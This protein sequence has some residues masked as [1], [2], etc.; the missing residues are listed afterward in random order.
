MT[1]TP[2]LSIINYEYGGAGA[3]YGA[4]D[5]PTCLE[6]DSFTT[7]N[8][9]TYTYDEGDTLQA[10]LAKDLK[11]EIEILDP[12]SPHITE[13]N[14]Q[15]DAH[16][17]TRV[18]KK[19]KKV[20]VK[21]EPDGSKTYR[22]VKVED[23]RLK[24][25]YVTVSPNGE[26]VTNITETGTKPYDNI[27]S[28]PENWDTE[29]KV[30]YLPDGIKNHRFVIE[31]TERL[32]ATVCKSILAKQFDPHTK[33]LPPLVIGGDH[34]QGLG[35][36]AGSRLAAIVIKL[37]EDDKLELRIPAGKT[38]EEIIDPIRTLAR[39]LWEL[40]KDQTSNIVKKAR[41]L[42]ASIE[43]L[44][45]Q[46]LFEIS[47]NEALYNITL[48]EIPR[49][50]DKTGKYTESNADYSKR[51]TA[52][53]RQKRG[54][55]DATQPDR[56]I[57]PLKELRKFLSTI[58]QFWFDAH[59]DW[60][61]EHTS[62]SKNAH[63]MPLAAICGHG[64]LS[65][66]LGT[67][68]LELNPVNTYTIGTRDTDTAEWELMQQL[69]TQTF[70]VTE[71]DKKAGE[72]ESDGL[73]S[74]TKDHSKE[75]ALKKLF[76]DTMAT[77][78]RET[79][80]KTGT[81]PQF[82]MSYDGDGVHATEFSATGTPVAR[83]GSKGS[84]AVHA[85]RGLCSKY[86]I[87]AHDISEFNPNLDIEDNKGFDSRTRSQLEERSRM[88]REDGTVGATRELTIRMALAIYSPSNTIDEAAAEISRSRTGRKES[89]CIIL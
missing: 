79:K 71:I 56:G 29:K 73:D 68:F 76:L 78:E 28:K 89:E 83:G 40:P 58:H 12:I 61:T 18:S 13:Q 41:E 4:Q 87:L 32:A 88:E 23:D 6:N 14:D 57:L 31:A 5:G 52:Y 20:K 33:H 70:R 75:L 62:E 34:T 67:G 59:G 16:L 77:A 45:D 21:D 48:K 7:R 9:K 17:V 44:I 63:G 72:L 30:P 37:I 53:I 25:Y 11:L 84:H 10:R 43:T 85:I 47:R 2:H 50:A 69:G 8:G 82:I 60:N 19:T 64:V 74:H 55:F 36:S 1:H 65:N 51:T 81:R 15:P 54:F 39:E 24:K 49:Q 42:A 22:M 35:T 3:Q 38:R 26:Q 80:E 86:D 27:Q 66:I 46:N